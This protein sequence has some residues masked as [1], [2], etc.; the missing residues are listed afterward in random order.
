M[1]DYG[2]GIDSDL[3]GTGEGGS[4]WLTG[5]YKAELPNLG[6]GLYIRCVFNVTNAQIRTILQI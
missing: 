5:L 4:G 3:Y 1:G 2:L 6:K